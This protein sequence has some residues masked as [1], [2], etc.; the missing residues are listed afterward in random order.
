[1]SNH[2]HLEDAKGALRAGS[3]S[4]MNALDVAYLKDRMEELAGT[5]DF[6]EANR[7]MDVVS[8]WRDER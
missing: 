6:T 4:Q 7:R 2:E 8:E 1:M 5:R 3:K